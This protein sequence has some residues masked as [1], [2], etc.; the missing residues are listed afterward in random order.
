[1]TKYWVELA[2]DYGA[3]HEAETK[4]EAVNQVFHCWYGQHND[5]EDAPEYLLVHNDADINWFYWNVIH[6]SGEHVDDIFA[7][8]E[9]EEAERQARGRAMANVKLAYRA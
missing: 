8:D 2:A 6:T 7:W 3:W 9:D 4:E 1:M 5:D